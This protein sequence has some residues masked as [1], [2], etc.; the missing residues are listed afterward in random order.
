M[1]WFN[2]PPTWAEMERVLDGKPRHAG[3][4][5]TA[6]PADDAPLSHKRGAYRPPDDTRIV[7]SSIAY[8]ELHAH[9]AFSFL[10]GA[11]TPEELVEEAVRL[12]LHAIALTDHNGLY[13]AVRFAEAA[14]E[15]DMRT[16]FGAELSLGPGARTDDP[17]PAGSY[18]GTNS[19]PSIYEPPP[20]IHPPNSPEG[21]SDEMYSLHAGGANVLFA[22]GSV[23]FLRDGTSIQVVAALATRAGGEVIPEEAY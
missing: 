16:V 1:G 9:S 13:G 20:V 22:D 11:S 3:T 5:G 21:D 17:D 4:P 19:G 7:R 8:A 18:V 15:L 23:H 6:A 12:D 10:D 14:T 2:G